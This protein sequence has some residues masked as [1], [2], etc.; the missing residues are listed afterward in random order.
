MVDCKVVCDGH[1]EWYTV[2]KC[3]GGEGMEVLD[4]DCC[5]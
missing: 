1:G 3:R 4:S 5:M 2:V